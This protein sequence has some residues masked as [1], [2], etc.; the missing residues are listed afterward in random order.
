MWTVYKREIVEKEKE[1]KDFLKK[2][3][4]RNKE[5]YEKGGGPAASGSAPSS[6]ATPSS[7]AVPT[8]ESLPVELDSDEEPLSMATV[9]RQIS[10]ERKREEEQKQQQQTVLEQFASG[11]DSRLEET[12]LP[13]WLYKYL[14]FR[15]NMLDRTGETHRN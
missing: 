3:Y 9:Q 5:H 11:E 7:A 12:K 8:Y 2:Y 13:K 6:G 4:H 15:F 1:E 10:G 14:V